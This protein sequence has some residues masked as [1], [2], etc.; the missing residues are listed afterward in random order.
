[1]LEGNNYRAKIPSNLGDF[2][3]EGSQD[4]VEKQIDKI[5]SIQQVSPALPAR[6]TETKKPETK[7]T[8]P[9]R[10][11]NNGQSK[12]SS[13]PQPSVLNDLIPK[14]KIADLRS[15]H[16]LKKPVNH[17]DHYSVLAYWIKEKL[18]VVDLSLNEMWT[19][20]KILG[21]RPPKIPIQT[22]RDAK[23]KK[24]FFDSSAEGKYFL[25]SIGE[26]YVE[27]DLPRNPKGK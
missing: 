22:F 8:P 24:S 6:P 14:E 27:H 2:E 3:F 12:K 21:L 26:T 9:K 11:G 23:S 10:T 13:S 25:T 17:I 7:A 16:D 20:Y 18:N 15:F 19:M 1:M 5:L 4:F